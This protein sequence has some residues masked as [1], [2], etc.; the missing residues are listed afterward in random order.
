MNPSMNRRIRKV[1][2]ALLAAVSVAGCASAPPSRDVVLERTELGSASVVLAALDITAVW[3]RQVFS[4]F[5]IRMQEVER[6]QGGRMFKGNKGE[7][8]V[9]ANLKPASAAA[10]RVEIT[11]RKNLI[12]LD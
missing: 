6:L 9:T 3:T 2:S 11:V 4:D 1:L 10:T 12:G 7:L 8:E 5:D